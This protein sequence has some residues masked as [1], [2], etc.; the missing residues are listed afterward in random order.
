MVIH[1]LPSVIRL[2]LSLAQVACHAIV[3][4][5]SLAQVARQVDVL[6]EKLREE[7]KSSLQA[8][9]TILSQ[10]GLPTPGAAVK[11]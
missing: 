9:E 5:T 4:S 2:L 10:A 8:L 11:A 6:E 3:S 7:Q 1:G